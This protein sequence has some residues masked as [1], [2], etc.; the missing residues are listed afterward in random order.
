MSGPILYGPQFSYFLRA[1]SLLFEFK[2]LPY[3][4]SKAPFGEELPLFGEG[5][6]KLHPFLKMP[7]LIDGDFVLPE[8]M[9]IARY[10]ENQPGPSF[11]PG[12]ARL[13]ARIT[14]VACMIWQYVHKPIVAN[15]LLEFRFPKGEGG[16]IRFEVL[17]ENLPQAKAVLE[18]VLAQLDER[19]FIV[20]EQF[21]LAD[22]YL[23]P[24]LDYLHQLPEPWSL[25][26]QHSALCNYIEYHRAQAYSQRVLLQPNADAPTKKRAS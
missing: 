8:T 23:I 24:M 9:A 3:S 2:G 19:L 18:W 17:N 12:D 25:S 7:V 6:R 16:K 26:K 20:G 15:M 14:S 11:L 13:Q 5:H 21:T 1:S 4:V 22:A 10:L